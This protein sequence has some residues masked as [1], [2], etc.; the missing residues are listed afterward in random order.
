MSW[1]IRDQN[2]M[3]WRTLCPGS[4]TLNT[5][6]W[7]FLGVIVPTPQCVGVWEPSGGSSVLTC[8]FVLKESISSCAKSGKESQFHASPPVSHWPP[9]QPGTKCLPGEPKRKKESSALPPPTWITPVAFHF[10]H[11][12]VLNGTSLLS[13][14]AHWLTVTERKYP[15]IDSAQLR[16]SNWI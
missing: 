2:K 12:T 10:I 13:M 8:S 16:W 11:A 1:N 3:R 6:N 5:Y 15:H 7:V 9:W 14:D 4:L